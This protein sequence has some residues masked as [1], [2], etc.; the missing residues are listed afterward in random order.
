MAAAVIDLEDFTCSICKF[1]QLIK[2]KRNFPFYQHID[3]AFFSQE[4]VEGWYQNHGKQRYINYSQTESVE[5]QK[6]Y[7]FALVQVFC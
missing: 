6:K 3:K 2:I 7:F 1:N 4:I 5:C